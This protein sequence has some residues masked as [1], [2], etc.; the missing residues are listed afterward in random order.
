MRVK[1][2]LE[3]RHGREPEPNSP[4]KVL[5]DELIHVESN[6][7]VGVANRPSEWRPPPKRDAVERP[8]AT[9]LKR[10]A[11]AWEE[12][13][14]LM[15]RERIAAEIAAPLLLSS[16]SFPD[17]HK[18]FAREGITLRRKGTNGAVLEIA[19]KEVCI[20]REN[21]LSALEG[22]YGSAFIAAPKNLQI[23]D[24]G[25]RSMWGRDAAM[26]TYYVAKRAHDAE[27]RQTLASVRATM[28]TRGTPSALILEV[29]K[30]IAAETSFPSAIA[31]AGGQAAPAI[32]EIAWSRVGVSCVA[33]AHDRVS[34]TKSASKD[35]PQNI[36]AFYAF[37]GRRGATIYRRGGAAGEPAF[38][39]LGHVVIVHIVD[40]ETVRAVLRLLAGRDGKHSVKVL[41][42]SKAFRAMVAQIAEEDGI[43]IEREPPSGFAKMVKTV[44]VKPIV[45]VPATGR[46]VASDD[47]VKLPEPAVR[48]PVMRPPASDEQTSP[49]GS[50]IERGPEKAQNLTTQ[51]VF[52][53]EPR[54]EPDANADRKPD[55]QS[56][57]QK[58]RRR[59][60]IDHD[61]DR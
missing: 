7:A 25:P 51:P 52:G 19:G 61:M 14:G 34:A 13:T 54:P 11:L 32:A 26:E 49:I 5:A 48:Q 24:S 29:S 41:S 58:W 50:T 31:F 37:P 57:A 39:D 45:D 53:V 4:Y 33:P 44:F 46:S 15:S 43:P 2:V 40:K 60:R 16:K 27:I 8:K 12:E 1:T 20:T 3:A 21:R 18:A 9:K 6:W 35:H 42:G 30:A 47:T 36:G 56:A 28:M 38:V 59:V 17:A 55:E 22:R 10:E 23:V